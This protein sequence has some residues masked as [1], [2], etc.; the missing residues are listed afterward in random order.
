MIRGEKG[1]V[2]KSKDLQEP[3]AR[4]SLLGLSK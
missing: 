3:S 2:G 4:L 1:F